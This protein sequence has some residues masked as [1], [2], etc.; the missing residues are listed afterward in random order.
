MLC[1]SALA[2]YKEGALSP[3]RFEA[4]TSLVLPIKDFTMYI[5]SL[6][7]PRDR[8]T[9]SLLQDYCIVKLITPNRLAYLHTGTALWRGIVLYAL[10]P[11]TMHG[12]IVGKRV[13][14]RRLSDRYCTS[15]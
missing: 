6:C 14:T 2:E 9:H 1:Q 8:C 4:W 3:S 7:N 10:V 15:V 5:S 11:K 12:I 13:R